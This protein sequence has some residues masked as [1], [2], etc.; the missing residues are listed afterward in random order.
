MPIQYKLRQILLFSL[1][2]KKKKTKREYNSSQK[3]IKIYIKPK[4]TKNIHSKTIF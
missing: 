2:V 3:S 1:F 4:R